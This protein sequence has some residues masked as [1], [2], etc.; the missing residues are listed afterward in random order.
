MV[1]KV[2]R[3]FAYLYG[4]AWAQLFALRLA[5]WTAVC[6]IYLFDVR[7]FRMRPNMARRFAIS[8]AVLLFITNYNCRYSNQIK[9]VSILC[10]NTC[11]DC[12]I[13]IIVC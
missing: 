13:S 4:A 10:F 6:L 3:S 9:H 11:M 2:E 12:D 1:Y 5:H 8:C 7:V